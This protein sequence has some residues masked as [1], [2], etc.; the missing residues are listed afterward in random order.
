MSEWKIDCVLHPDGLH[1][2]PFGIG[3]LGTSRGFRWIKCPQE[4]ERPCHFPM[5]VA[6][7]VFA[8]VCPVFVFAVAH[9]VLLPIR[10]N[11]LDLYLPVSGNFL[12]CPIRA[13]ELERVF[14]FGCGAEPAHLLFFHR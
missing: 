4:P 9:W 6:A 1:I 13:H 7:M 5:K 2:P 8:V 3:A 11:P 10:G 12:L 14:L